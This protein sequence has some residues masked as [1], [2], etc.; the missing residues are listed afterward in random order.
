MDRYNRVVRDPL[1]HA[2]LWG[3]IL[4]PLGLVIY[5]LAILSTGHATV[6]GVDL[7]GG[8][9]DVYGA[10]ATQVALAWLALAAALHCHLAWGRLPGSWSLGKALALVLYLLAVALY[11]AAVV[12]VALR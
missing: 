7:L 12:R 6:F 2:N 10:D 1:K 9:L 3:G 8:S 11:L 4:L 5:G